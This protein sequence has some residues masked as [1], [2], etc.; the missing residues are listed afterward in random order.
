MT[1]GRINQIHTPMGFDRPHGAHT[2][3]RVAPPLLLPGEREGRPLPPTERLFFFSFSSNQ[4]DTLWSWVPPVGSAD[5]LH[6]HDALTLRSFGSIVFHSTFDIRSGTTAETET[7]TGA[8][9]VRPGSALSVRASQLVWTRHSTLG[10]SPFAPV[11]IDSSH[12]D[13]GTPS[14]GFAP[15]L[16]VLDACCPS[17]VQFS[18]VRLLLFYFRPH[19]IASS[20]FP[21]SP[22]SPVG[23]WSEV[24]PG[25]RPRP[26]G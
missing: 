8:R 13:V 19:S 17:P 23:G 24:V 2:P 1:A 3:G 26:C 12:P 25:D 9:A 11:T 20:R 22:R 7:T 14:P 15:R 18:S 4:T 5:R 10:F 6:R 21:P 16:C